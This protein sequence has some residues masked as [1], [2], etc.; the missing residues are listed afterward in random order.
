MRVL[1]YKRTHSGDPDSRGRFGIHGCMGRVR[2]W[3]FDAVIGFGGIGAQASANGLARK[4]TWVGI[5]PH[6]ALGPDPRG[7]LVTFDDFKHFG[8]DGPDAFTLAP[9]L[10]A[11]I[12]RDNVRAQVRGFTA[13]E[14]RE[15]KRILT[16]A[17]RSRGSPTHAKEPPPAECS[18]CPPTRRRGITRSCS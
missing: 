3:T 8:A 16:F 11:R 14:Q 6:R 10:A 13:R 1:V 18:S 7:P 4:I 9:A 2:S 12:Y 5:G 15:I 17:K